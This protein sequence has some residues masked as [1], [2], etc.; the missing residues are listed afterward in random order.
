MGKLIL[1]AI[2]CFAIY[3]ATKYYKARP[4]EKENDYSK[5]ATS[6]APESSEVDELIANFNKK[7]AEIES[8]SVEE[9]KKQEHLL[10]YYKQE[11]QKLTNLKNR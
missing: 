9:I 8:K 3:W 5:G 11:L 1:F 6:V 2:I 10:Q 4:K 7:I